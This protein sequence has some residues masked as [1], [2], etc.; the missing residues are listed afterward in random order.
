LLEL[1][2]FDEQRLGWASFPQMTEAA[3]R[4]LPRLRYAKGI[5]ADG[6]LLEPP[7]LWERYLEP[8]YRDRALRIRKDPEEKTRNLLLGDNVRRAYGLA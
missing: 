1:L 2:R 7:D 4:P 3:T 5:D 8:K 6:H